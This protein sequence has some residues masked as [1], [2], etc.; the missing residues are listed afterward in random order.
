MSDTATM[1]MPPPEA[2][3]ERSA[4]E[5][6]DAPA[7]V[8]WPDWV[9]ADVESRLKRLRQ[10]LEARAARTNGAATNGRWHAT[11]PAAARLAGTTTGPS[12]FD[13]LSRLFELSPFEEDVL[14]LALGPE[15]DASLGDLLAAVQGDS[16]RPYPSPHLALDLFAGSFADRVVARRSFLAGSP[17]VRFRLI[18]LED[19]G[20]PGATTS[21]AVLRLEPRI[22]N[23]L[24]GV[25][26]PDDG[27]RTLLERV[28]P[29]PMWSAHEALTDELETGL[30]PLLAG[31]PRPLLNVVGVSGSG[32]HVLAEGLCRRLGLGLFQ[33]DVDAL[34]ADPTERR[35]TLQAVDR[36]AVLSAF[37]LYV[38]ATPQL[39]RMHALADVLRDRECFVIAGSA[40]PVDVASGALV[41]DI[42]APDAAASLERWRA[43][44]GA[45]FPAGED[46]LDLAEQFA[47]GPRAIQRAATDALRDAA[48]A[49][50]AVSTADLVRASRRHA[51]SELDDLARRLEPRYGWDDIVLP[52]DLTEQLH[53]IA[54]QVGRRYQVYERWGFGTKLARGRGITV[55]FAGPS[56]TGKTMA[57]EVLAHELGLDL[58]RIDLAGV[59]SKYIGETEKN[60]RRLFDAA[61]RSGS[62][63]LFDEA[64]ALFGKR[65]EVRD[66]H[67]RYANIEINYLLQRMEDY[68]GLAI[69]ATNMRSLLDHAFLRRLRFILDFPFPDRAMR[70]SIWARVF[71]PEAGAEIDP[72][73]LSRL[74]V[75]G[76]SIRSIAVNAAF[77]AAGEGGPIGMSHVM[78]AARREYT[79]IDKLVVESDFRP[80]PGAAA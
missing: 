9:V 40:A 30:R 56:G 52:P 20:Y 71:P 69:L 17:L 29:G 65:T 36:D 28:E 4:A 64:D 51:G 60:L 41:V 5:R 14:A 21:D 77:L 18:R 61:E 70:T 1:T 43:A 2:S 75:A 8:A 16:R 79:K 78:R 42:P 27:V 22:A 34:S 53:E 48:T 6:A 68:R 46:A 39:E 62:V 49:D 74:E 45:T 73:A 19:P 50:R 33:L 26:R 37:A 7:A 55:L 67:D 80:R 76:G 31:H 10:V 59:V 15:L 23:L 35:R 12:G 54:G 11:T 24:L 72:D 38:D 44:L 57:A 13:L 32:R 66:S 63:L 3:T 58:Y 47:I 25:N